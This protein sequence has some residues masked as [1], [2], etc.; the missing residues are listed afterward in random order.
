[1]VTPASI[2]WQQGAQVDDEALLVF[3][4]WLTEIM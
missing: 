3:I 4:S 2:D 1:M